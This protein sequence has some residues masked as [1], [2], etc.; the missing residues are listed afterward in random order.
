MM[1]AILVF[2]CCEGCDCCCPYLC[3]LFLL[4]YSVAVAAACYFYG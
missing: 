1:L 3:Y 4:S 2:C